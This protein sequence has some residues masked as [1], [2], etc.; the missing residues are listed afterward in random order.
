MS[1]DHA[2]SVPPPVHTAPIWPI[3]AS[4]AASSPTVGA[5]AP[6]SE[7]VSGKPAKPEPSIPV[8]MP[9]IRTPNATTTWLFGI[10]PWVA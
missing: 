3:A 9:A 4:V 10:Q 2:T 5:S 8:I 1:D 6:E 7:P